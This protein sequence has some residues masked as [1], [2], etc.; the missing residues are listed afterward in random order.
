MAYLH[1]DQ[2]SFT[3]AVNLAGKYFQIPPRIIEKD[4]YVTMILRELSSRLPFMVFKGGTSLSKCYQVIDRFSEDIDI[5]TD[6]KLTQG[7][8]RKLKAEIQNIA[9]KLGLQI[10]N[11]GETRSRQ[12]F[13]RYDLTYRSILN[14]KN[15]NCISSSVILETAFAEVSFPTVRLPVRSYIGNMMQTEAPEAI[16]GYGLSP[17][18]MKV[19]RIDRTF[20][21]KVFA[22]C[23]YYLQGRIKKYSRH[24]YD[25]Y[26]L[27]PLVA[28]NEDMKLLVHKVRLVRVE[29]SIC[30][31]AQPGVNI[32]E[33]LHEIVKTGIYK[34]DYQTIT[35][36]LLNEPVSYETAIL[37][38]QK[39]ADSGIFEE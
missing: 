34:E 7:Q 19:Q 36:L 39:I 5:T 35:S 37:A 29:S 20:A 14:Y 22:I 6:T 12:R 28:L 18:E 16:H 1:E 31:S 9:D 13:N 15:D 23:D 33:L 24:I 26:K 3:A 21:D 11:I 10:P 32:P 17:F 25:I 8:M 30:P 2:K 4:Y 27:L 38:I